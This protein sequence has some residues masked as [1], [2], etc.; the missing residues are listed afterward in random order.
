MLQSF[1]KGPEATILETFIVFR[2][3]QDCP[4]RSPS[5]DL[6]VLATFYSLQKGDKS[7]IRSR[8]PSP[9]ALILEVPTSRFIGPV[10][11]LEPPEGGRGSYTNAWA[12]REPGPA[13]PPDTLA[14][15]YRY[16]YWIFRSLENDSRRRYPEGRRISFAFQK[17]K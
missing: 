16:L 13:G 8:E 4:R 2:D 1:Q 6:S 7:V 5:H 9:A 3:L 15:V 11:V 10:D 14:H 12:G 17:H